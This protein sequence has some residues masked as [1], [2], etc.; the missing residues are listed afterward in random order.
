M[1]TAGLKLVAS[2]GVLLY[3]TC[4]VEPEENEGLFRDAPA[5]FEPE[6]LG[7]A[8]PEGVPWIPTS[9]GGVRILPN[10][11][12]DGFTIHALRRR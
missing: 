7:P 6:D 4:S 12:G 11:M 1:L 2:G 8:L 3:S 5:G 10:L 9:A